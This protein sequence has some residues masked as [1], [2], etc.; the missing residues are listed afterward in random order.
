MSADMLD[1]V[2]VAASDLLSRV[3][4]ALG[5]YGAPPA[6]PVWV[7]ARRVGATPGAA[8]AHFERL[9][10]ARLR[11]AADRLR[12][13]ASDVS[14]ALA[15]MPDMTWA[16]AAAAAYAAKRDALDGFANAADDR[17][18]AT[19]DQMKAVAEWVDGSRSR[20]A[21]DLASC[22]ASHEA[23]VVRTG[24]G[25]QVALA[26]ADLAERVLRSVAACVDD[27]WNVHAGWLGALDP[28]GWTEPVTDVGVP[29]RVEFR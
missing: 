16:G 23:V 13:S 29:D 24:D 12:S 21:R 14:A 1:R 8:V 22:L 27:G 6:H 4:V 18:R 10:A 20:I 9:D 11:D 28:A 2:Q 15:D 17:W 19:A 25:A 3:D 26:A 7:Q 5:T